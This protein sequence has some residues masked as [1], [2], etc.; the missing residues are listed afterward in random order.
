MREEIEVCIR[1][2]F[3]EIEEN[4]RKEQED[5][6]KG[7]LM[8][9]IKEIVKE[10]T[11]QENNI[12]TKESS[13]VDA[14]IVVHL[15]ENIIENTVDFAQKLKSNQALEDEKLKKIDVEEKELIF[16]YEDIFNLAHAHVAKVE[17]KL[18]DHKNDPGGIT[19]HGISLSFLEDYAK[20]KNGRIVL[21]KLKIYTVSRNSIIKMTGEQ[22]KNIM[23]NAFWLATEIAKLPPLLAIIAYD[24]AVNSGS[25]YASRLIQRAI[26][27]KVDGIIGNETITKANNLDM[28][29]QKK[30][31]KF[32]LE[33]R[34]KF[35]QNLA[36]SKP[37]MAVF[38]KGWLNRVESMRVYLNEIS[39]ALPHKHEK[40]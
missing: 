8:T 38:L 12:A 10:N 9:E 34:V 5:C 40:N 36:R 15:A 13:H 32:M 25:Y 27:A 24:F 39:Q 21:N 14:S 33:E 35:Y 22:A 29:A 16:E 1:D 6:R 28:I 23:Y 37:K 30:V 3:L 17:G 18:V 11:V 7:D 2:L 19:N 31:A 26:G 4:S 20:T